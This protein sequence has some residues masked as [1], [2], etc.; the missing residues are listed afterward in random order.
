VLRLPSS[1]RVAHDD[2]QARELRAHRERKDRDRDQ[3]PAA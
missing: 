2:W 1:L 3:P